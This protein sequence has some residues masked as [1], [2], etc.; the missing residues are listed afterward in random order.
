MNHRWKAILG[1]AALA[2]ALFA[3][4]YFG[5]AGR[6]RPILAHAATLGPW[7][8]ALFFALYVAATVLLLPA[9]ILTLGAG[10]FYGP[11]RGFAL[12]WFSATAGAAAAF[13]V[14]RYLAREW[15]QTKLEGNSRFRS[16][17][18]AVGREGWKIIGLTRLTPLFPFN[19]LNYAFGISRVSF[20]DYI[21]AT[22]IGIVPGTAFYV[23]LGSI[24][25]DA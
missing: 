11:V 8:P 17:D 4:R 19:L 22:W 14:S 1:A 9:S 23:Y 21:L 2:A 25:G 20:R 13:L 16:V 3:A 6:I 12:V 24:A 5:L 18:E 10:A 7:G 15:V